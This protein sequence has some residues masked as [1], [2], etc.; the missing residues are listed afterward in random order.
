MFEIETVFAIAE[1]GTT[2][3]N[4]KAITVF[5]LAFRMETVAAFGLD[6]LFGGSGLGMVLA[7]H[8][9]A[10]ITTILVVLQALAILLIT[11]TLVLFTSISCSYM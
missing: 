2:N 5:F 1:R 4:C 6:D 7:V 11:P 3:S 9:V 10:R 8:T